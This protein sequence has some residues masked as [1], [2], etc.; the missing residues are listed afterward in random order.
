LANSRTRRE[1]IQ[2]HIEL[3]EKLNEEKLTNLNYTYLDNLGA[4]PRPTDT[5]KKN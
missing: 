3:I 1:P 5:P 2:D 4:L